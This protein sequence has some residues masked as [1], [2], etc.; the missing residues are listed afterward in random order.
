M[1]SKKNTVKSSNKL[2]EIK[3]Q[4]D[5]LPEEDRAIL[6]KQ[7]IEYTQEYSGMLPPPSMLREFDN[8]IPNGADRLMTM[9]ETEAK[10]RHDNNRKYLKY[11]SI[12]M[13]LA[14]AIAIFGFGS[15]LYLAIQ[16]NNVGAGIMAG[17]VMLGVITAFINGK[18]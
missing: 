4:L 1:S 6:L 15:A 7:Q 18:K 5:S 2:S 8:I 9:L 16:G 17:T 12:G 10:E 3:K 14:F 13:F 11:T